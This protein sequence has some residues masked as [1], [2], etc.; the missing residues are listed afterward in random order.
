MNTLYSFLIW[1]F[2]KYSTFEL[3]KSDKNPI[4]LIPGI[5]GN[6][7]YANIK[8]YEDIPWKCRQTKTFLAWI[9]EVKSLRFECLEIYLK[10]VYNATNQSYS[11]N[12]GIEIEVPSV[13]PV[14]S[15]NYLDSLN[16]INYYQTVI[17]HFT[18]KYG[19]TE[20]INIQAY[21]CDFRKVGAINELNAYKNELKEY[22]EKYSRQ[23]NSSIIIFTHSMGGLLFNHFQNSMTQ[24]WL[25]KYIFKWVSLSTPFA[26]SIKSISSLITGIFLS[27]N[28]EFIHYEKIAEI[29]RTY[30]SA[31]YLF[32]DFDIFD[33]S[34]S[35][36]NMNNQT[37]KLNDW[38]KVLELLHIEHQNFSA[39]IPKNFIP[40][41]PKVNMLCIFSNG[42]DTPKNLTFR[43]GS[44]PL[45]PTIDYDDG[46]GSVNIE[47]LQVCS[48]YEKQVPKKIKAFKLNKISHLQILHHKN[49]FQII[50]DGLY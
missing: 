11:D 37:F 32:P 35:V 23:F 17:N 26:G 31:Y 38:K 1:L 9:N 16:I 5:S 2:V 25:D 46:D 3:I 48:Q 33:P 6:K 24:K 39:H 44:F 30:P 8:N 12:N 21:P 29:I 47:S 22:I 34:K 20:N 49:M 50:D 4:L 14:N 41:A 27:L 18:K 42:I 45:I 36:I 43:H 13:G 28:L 7:L 15:I 19:Y 40:A 10:L